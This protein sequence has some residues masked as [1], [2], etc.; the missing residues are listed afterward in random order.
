M[1]FRRILMIIGILAALGAGAYILYN[2][3][4]TVGDAAGYDDGYLAGHKVGYIEGNQDGYNEGYDLGQ[5]E[6]YSEG[7]TAGYT[8]GYNAGYA[9]GIEAG[10]GHGYCLRDPS[11]A[12]AVAFLNH[13]RTDRNH[14]DEDS[15]VCSH[16]S[17]DVCNN[18]EAEGLRCAFVELRYSDSG[19]S[20]IAFD[21]IDRG[22]VYF[23]PQFDDEVSLEI[24]R[25]YSQLNGYVIPSFDDVIRDILVI[26]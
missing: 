11:Y 12:E 22:L 15:Y 9:E 21:T 19:H 5:D 1:W 4:Y 23:E 17:R 13:D 6:G 7:E 20:I 16:F 2:A 26:W 3:A 10:T 24:G 8:V 14:Y 18:A 25:R